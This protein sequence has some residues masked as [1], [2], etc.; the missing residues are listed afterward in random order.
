MPE[1]I[2]HK[3]IPAP[4]SVLAI[5]SPISVREESWSDDCKDDSFELS[6]SVPKWF[7]SCSDMSSGANAPTGDRRPTGLS[8]CGICRSVLPLVEGF[9][10]VGRSRTFGFLGTGGGTWIMKCKFCLFY[11]A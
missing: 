2:A 4:M 9:S 1:N 11:F 7:S 3:Y 8:D 10:G 5:L 6:L